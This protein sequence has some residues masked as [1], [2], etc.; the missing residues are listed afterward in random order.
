MNVN[1]L[2]GKVERPEQ[3]TPVEVVRKGRLDLMVLQTMAR[4]ITVTL[5]ALQQIGEKA[6]PLSYAFEEWRGRQHRMIIFA[7]QELLT[8]EEMRF[9]GFVSGRNETAEQHIVDAIFRADELMLAEL[10]RIPG[11]LSYSSLELRPCTWYNLVLFRDPG[12]KSHVKGIDAHRHAA[13][14]LSPAYYAWI[15]LNNGVLSGGLARPEW[16]LNNTKH[17]RFFGAQQP[18]VVREVTYETCTGAC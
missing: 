17:Y 7:P 12:V 14:L 5:R 3:S 18:P 13:Y 16:H 10:A 2:S 1:H 15:R 9:V 8:S 6:L 4:K 11:L